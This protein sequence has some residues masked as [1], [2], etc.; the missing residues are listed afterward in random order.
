MKIGVRAHD[1]GRLG[2]ETMAERLQAAGYACTQLAMPKAFQEIDNYMEVDL[3]TIE[4]IRSAFESRKIE[5]A[6]LGC[7]VDLGNPDRDIRENAVRLFKK[8]LEI[9]KELGA[10]VVGTETA[11]TWLQGAER[12]LWYPYMLDS[13]KRIVEEAVRLDV[14]VALEPVCGHPLYD[15]DKVQQVL[16]AL[17]EE[18]HLRL[19]F[20]ASNV[21]GSIGQ[22]AQDIYWKEWLDGV[23][24]NIEV[25]HLKNLARNEQG[26]YQWAMLRDGEMDYTSI[27]AWINKHKP[28]M[29]LLREEMDPEG[30]DED[31]RFI[32]ETFHII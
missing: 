15:I 17:Q 2:I 19:I 30:A 3:R 4:R 26:Q 8:C 25:M 21:F 24:K 13:V 28:D 20:D 10:S 29:Y 32:K 12:D 9:N 11:C 6:V 23:G 5:I 14:K 1:Y 31:I 16:A 18:P 7:Y 27:A 22:K